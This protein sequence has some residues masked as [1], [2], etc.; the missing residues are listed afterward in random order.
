METKQDDVHL[1]KV[2][3][4][5]YHQSSIDMSNFIKSSYRLVKKIFT[6]EARRELLMNIG[7]TVEKQNDGAI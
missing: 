4:Q 1:Q 7:L 2:K 5:W 6:S 3:K